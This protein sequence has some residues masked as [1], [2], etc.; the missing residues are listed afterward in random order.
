MHIK[1]HYRQHDT[2]DCAAACLCTIFNFYG[3][4]SSI[5]VLREELQI[6]RNGANLEAIV[7]VSCKHGFLVNAYQG[8]FGSLI[9]SLMDKEISYPL[10]AHA[11]IE[12]YEHYIIIENINNYNVKYYDPKGKIVRVKRENFEQIWTGYIIDIKP[13]DV[14][15]RRVVNNKEN[16]WGKYNNILKEEKE[17]LG[18]ILLASII[19]SILSIIDALINQ[20]LIDAVISGKKIVIQIFSG[21]LNLKQIIFLLL[22]L[23]VSQIVISGAKNIVL[24]KVQQNT[25]ILLSK[26]Y[27]SHIFKLPF[28]Y[29]KQWNTGELLS[30]YQDMGK[31]HNFISNLILEIIFDIMMLVVG[32]IALMYVSKQLFVIVI[33]MVVLYILI[34]LMYKN[35]ISTRNE[36]IMQTNSD[37]I[38]EL[39]DYIDGIETIKTYSVETKI[40]LNMTNLS[41]KLYEFSRK[42]DLLDITEGSLINFISGMGNLLIIIGGCILISHGN[43]TIG[44]LIAF[45]SLIGYFVEPVLGLVNIQPQF[46]AALIAK[47]RLDDIYIVK[48][49]NNFSDEDE[50]ASYFSKDIS[51]SHISFRYG[52]REYIFKDLSCCIKGGEKTL[53]IGKSGSGKTT[54]VNILKG[55]IPLKEGCITYGGKNIQEI[56]P[57]SLRKE[58]AYVSQTPYF[59]SKSIYENLVPSNQ[60]VDSDEMNCVIEGC[61]LSTLLSSLPLGINTILS[62]NAKDLSGGQKQRLSIARAL[63]GHPKILIIDEGTNQLDPYTEQKVL[64]FI[65]K[66]LKNCTIIQI[67]HNKNSLNKF[68]NIYELKDGK[69]Q[70]VDKV[71]INGEIWKE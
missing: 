13:R 7:D 63:L 46:Q 43:L 15:T 44:S 4:T 39:K 64:D 2:R 58:V 23:L 18:L 22:L 56:S 57:M 11:I 47:E 71:S 51:L 27:F 55:F 24:S 32:G 3:F 14:I 70:K 33:L 21:C 25:G 42:L 52:Y 69:I 28:L 9:K 45:Q 37:L 36:E 67:S 68:E 38:S 40:E 50:D 19:V 5:A 35:K 34:M 16:F 26:K 6:D 49:E 54:L 65:D 41:S 8:N 1:K 60:S 20:K 62:E 17:K 30:R 66:F 53:I 59:F 31:I 10:M 29:Y 61:E 12:G 48:S